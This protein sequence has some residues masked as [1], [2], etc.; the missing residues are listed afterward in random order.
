MCAANGRRIPSGRRRLGVSPGAAVMFE[1]SVAG[2]A[3]GCTG[4][5]GMLW[6][7]RLRRASLSCWSDRD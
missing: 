5:F 7:D 3:A 1:D 4:R 6:V 2:V